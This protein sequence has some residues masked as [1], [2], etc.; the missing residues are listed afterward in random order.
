[1]IHLLDINVLVAFAWPTHIHHQRTH[2]WFASKRA[3]TP[4][5]VA[6]CPISELGFL[7]VSMR[8]G[9]DFSTAMSLL[10][11]FLRRKDFKFHFWNEDFSPAIEFR[12]SS[13]QGPNQLTDFYLAE[14]AHR[15]KAKFA[16]LDRGISHSSVE[17][18]P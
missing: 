6:T 3:T 1:V 10:E 2:S 18:I 4:M 8:M 12:S 17:M 5:N 7:R 15:N 16:T 9:A 14:L 11:T 13:I